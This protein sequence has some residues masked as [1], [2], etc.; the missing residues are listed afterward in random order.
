MSSAAI[1]PKRL[2]GDLSLPRSEGNNLNSQLR[3]Q[4]VD[5]T[6]SIVTTAGLHDDSD[7]DEIC[8]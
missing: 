4:K 8:G 2:T 5:I 7:L 6:C 1:M 3:K